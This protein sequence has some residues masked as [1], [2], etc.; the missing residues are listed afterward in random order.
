MS[1][2]RPSSLRN[3]PLA[4]R[5]RSRSSLHRRGRPSRRTFHRLHCP[6]LRPR[7]KRTRTHTNSRSKRQHHH[8]RRTITHSTNS[9]TRTTRDRPVREPRHRTSNS[10]GPRPSTSPVGASN[11]RAPS[12]GLS[13]RRWAPSTTIIYGLGDWCKRTTRQPRSVAVNHPG[14]WIP[15]RRFE[16][17]RGYFPFSERQLLIAALR[18]WRCRAVHG[19][20]A[21]R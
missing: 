1:S 16:S 15:G 20:R 13:S 21:T 8:N 12:G 10:T 4:R 19:A 18:Y 6:N 14:L 5:V 2:L 7:I 17:V 9:P 11:S 3:A